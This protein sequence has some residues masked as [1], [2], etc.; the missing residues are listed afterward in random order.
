MKKKKILLI[1]VA[2]ILILAIAF[3]CYIIYPKVRDK[4]DIDRRYNEF[5]KIQTLETKGNLTY[6]ENENYSKVEDMD[7]ITQDGIGAKVESISLN[8]D[9]LSVNFNFK[10]DEEFDYTTFGYSY[11][12]YDEN[13]NIYQ[14]SGRMHMGEKEKYDYGSLFMQRELGI[15][16]KENVSAMYLAD[17]GGLS[18]EVINEEEKTIKSDLNIG[19]EDKFPLSKKLYI[20]IFDLGYF[21]M[22]KDESGKYS[23]NTVKNKN[24]TNSKWLFEFDIPEE[25]NERNTINL[26]LAEEIPGLTMTKMTLTDTKL[27]LNFNSEEYI[28]LISAGKDMPA[29]EFM[30]KTREMLSITDGEGNVY[31]ELNSGTRG[32][33]GYKMVIDATKKDLDKKLY[34]NYKSGEEQYKVELVEDTNTNDSAKTATDYMVLYCGMEIK[35]EAGIQDVSEMKVENDA[36]KKYNTTYYN[37][38]NG[39]YEGTSDGK[40]SEEVYEGYSI[41]ENVKKIAMTQEYNAIPRDCK[42]I[43][44]LPNELK[45]MSDYSSVNIRQVDLDGDGNAENLLCYT[46]NYTKDQIGD[47]EP[48]ASSGI[49]LLDSNYK[50]IADLVTLE[51]GF[52]ANI[53]EEEN[54]VFLSLEDVD[55][56]DIDN[57]GIM[58]VIINMPTY[59]GTKLSI[60]KYKNGNIEGEKDYKASVLP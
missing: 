51:N 19:A 54:K 18:N 4:I 12:V 20:K 58:E 23:P 29:G 15:D 22:D 47:G 31:K 53:K 57:D 26:K 27:M 16:K 30:N 40:L 50:K 11:A 41:V 6:V 48:Q 2:F 5:E 33:N 34:L 17:S 36:N 45:D 38:E 55:C 25:M 44:E 42:E 52:W 46:V 8:D 7:Y 14:I 24:L 35:K 32:E 10:L 13:K 21:S 37:Y 9:T 49:M 28:N 56:I 39:K 59:E 60:V 3:A 1:I 43:N